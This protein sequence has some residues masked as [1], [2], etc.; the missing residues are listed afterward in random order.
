MSAPRT[1]PAG[2]CEPDD[3]P[4][5]LEP[6]LVTGFFLGSPWIDW[7][8]PAGRGVRV[9]PQNEP[10]AWHAVDGRCCH[11]LLDPGTKTFATGALIARLLPRSRG[12]GVASRR[13]GALLGWAD[14]IVTPQVY[15]P[16]QNTQPDHC[17]IIQ[18]VRETLLRISDRSQ[19]LASAT[20]AIALPDSARAAR[21]LDGLGSLHH[22]DREGIQV[23]L[24]GRHP[25]EVLGRLREGGIPV[26]GSV[27]WYPLLQ[28]RPDGRRPA[29]PSSRIRGY[30]PHP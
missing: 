22:S 3:L 21:L 20:L 17:G 24:E 1:A 14:R 12:V 25:E 11:L 30:P 4:H 15:P 10:V 23:R 29:S 13:A 6:G 7:T 2:R 26:T 27:L 28:C 18:L 16:S 19:V 9:I 5:L 8:A